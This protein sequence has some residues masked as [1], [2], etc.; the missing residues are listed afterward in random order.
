M[1][2]F[3]PLEKIKPLTPEKKEELTG[4]QDLDD[5]SDDG[6]EHDF[7]EDLSAGHQAAD[8]VIEERRL[9]VLRDQEALKQALADK[10]ALRKIKEREETW[11]EDHNDL[12]KINRRF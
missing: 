8:K 12:E 2:N 7:S 5:G 10:E 9:E 6:E 11:E 4:D 1:L 3:N